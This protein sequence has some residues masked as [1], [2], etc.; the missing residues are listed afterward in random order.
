MILALFDI[1]LFLLRLLS[2]LVIVQVIVSWL[3]AFNV[4]NLHQP[5]VRALYTGMERVTEPVYRPIRKV[6]PDFGGLDFSP[7]VLLLLIQV[8][9]ML[10]A[11]ARNDV[12]LA[13]I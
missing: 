13:T 4:V 12:L 7:I 3:V 9:S 11:G 6:L 2:I 5:F 1:V 10:V 8:I